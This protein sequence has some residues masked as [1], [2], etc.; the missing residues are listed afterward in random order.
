[1]ILHVCIN[2]CSTYL[3]VRPQNAKEQID[4]CQICTFCI[5]GR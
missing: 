3:R 5:P 1:M 2:R 4:M